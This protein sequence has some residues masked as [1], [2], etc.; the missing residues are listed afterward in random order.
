MFRCPCADD[1]HE[2]PYIVLTG[3]DLFETPHTW[4]E[5][6][7]LSLRH[8]SLLLVGVFDWSN[9]SRGVVSTICTYVKDFRARDIGLGLFCLGY[10]DI[11]RQICPYFFEAYLKAATEP[12]ILLIEQGSLKK[13]RLGPL[14][15][16]TLMSWIEEK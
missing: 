11:V 13:A 3:T 4:N 9:Y 6:V 10:E 16:V 2:Y 8:R 7:D 12:A 14:D 5:V 15:F 1:V